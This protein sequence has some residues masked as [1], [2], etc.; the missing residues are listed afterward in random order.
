MIEDLE[1]MAGLSIPKDLSSEEAKTYLLDACMKF[2]IK[3][4]PPQ[5]TTRL[6]D[7]VN[8]LFIFDAYVS[9]SIFVSRIWEYDK[10]CGL[11]I[12]TASLLGNPRTC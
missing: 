11:M 8:P 3:C 9:I 10:V 7:K 6:L 2:D 1:K 5:T 12:F 4:P